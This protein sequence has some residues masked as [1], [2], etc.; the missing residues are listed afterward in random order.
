MATYA[1]KLRE[2]GIDGTTIMMD[3]MGRLR[4]GVDMEPFNAP[5]S[6]SVFYVDGNRR[7]SGD[8]RTWQTAKKTLAEGLALA[9]AYGNASGNRAWA[10][11]ATVFA[12]GDSLTEDLVILAGR[13]DVIGV[14]TDNNQ[15][16]PVLIGNHVP[17]TTNCLGCR[18]INWKFAEVDAGAIWT[19]TAVSSGMKF[20][21][22]HFQG[23]GALAT[24][25]I[26]WTNSY[27]L[28]VAHCYFDTG[29]TSFTT[30]AI[31]IGAG[32]SD[33]IYIHD[34]VIV[35]ALGVVVDIAY[36]QVS[37]QCLIDNNV[38]RAATLAI[39][40]NSSLALITNNSLISAA[41]CGATGGTIGNCLDYNA[42]LACGNVVR[43]SDGCVNAPSTDQ[44]Y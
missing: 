32:V 36:T 15:D 25:G 20:I 5:N 12:C 14:G 42:L 30:G 2:T 27:S 23:R 10:Q 18:F 33:N 21:N 34:N 31:V 11:R 9:H 4:T 43:G 13:T 29:I 40:D 24:H 44:E 6:P 38:I 8:G 26:L 7:T 16:R 41:A 37:G 3:D 35:G 19:L 39:D 22:C 1:A 17:V 28:E